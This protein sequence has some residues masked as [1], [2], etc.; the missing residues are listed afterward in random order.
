MPR[1]WDAT[2]Y[3]SLPLPHLEWGRRTL[4]RLG[5]SGDERVLDLGCGTGRD[6]SPCSTASPGAE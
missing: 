1:E 5:L 3:D 4:D 6:T 2:T